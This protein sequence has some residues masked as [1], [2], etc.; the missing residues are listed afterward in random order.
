MRARSS[1]SSVTSSAPSAG[2]R[3]GVGRRDPAAALERFDAFLEG[4]H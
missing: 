1:P 2:F 4:R 3:I